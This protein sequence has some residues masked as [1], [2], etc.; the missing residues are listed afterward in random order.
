M[1]LTVSPAVKVFALLGILAMLLLAGGMFLLAPQAED[2]SI[3]EPLVLPKKKS[4]LLQVPAIE[5][6][7]AAAPT[8]AARPK[9]AKPQSA[10]PAPNA[11]P[12]PAP[13]VAKNGLPTVLVSALAEHAVV[14][15]S[16]YGDGGKVDPLARDEAEAGAK[17]ANVGFVALD[18]TRDQKAAEALLVKLGTVL[19]APAVLVYTRP[20]VFTIQLDGF[21]DRD[22]VAQ[23]AQ[24]ALP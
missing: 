18:V 24:N 8:A 23:A 14:V 2:T 13:V 17:L 12:K 6:K 11:K 9:T 20:D 21:R 10:A 5:K 16:L 4:A 1:S 3:D 7:K 22:T 19:R 15:V